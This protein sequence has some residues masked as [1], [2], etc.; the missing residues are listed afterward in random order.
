MVTGTRL[1]AAG[2]CPSDPR[3]EA[4][5]MGLIDLRLHLLLC[6]RCSARVS[7][8]IRE[9]EDFFRFVYPATRRAV[10]AAAA[11]LDGGEASNASSPAYGED[12]SP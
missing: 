5:L 2:S 10:L 1:L 11:P 6:S 4:H 9:G 8:M 12:C 7:Q 3:L